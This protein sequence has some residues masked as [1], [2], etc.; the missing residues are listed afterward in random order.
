[1]AGA[2]QLSFDRI[3]HRPDCIERWAHSIRQT[4]GG[5]VAIALELSKGPLVAA[6]QK[7]DFFVLFPIH[8]T[9]LARYRSAFVPSGAKDDPTDAQ[10]ALELLLRHPE[11]FAPF[12]PQSPSM[13]SLVSL[14]EHRRHLVE[15]KVRVSNRLCS[16]LKQY[17]PVM[18][19]LFERH[20]TAVFCDFLT[21]WPTIADIKRVRIGTLEKFFNEHNARNA[22]LNQKRGELIRQAMPLTEDPGIVEPSKSYT[23]ALVEQLKVIL[24][25]VKRLD[26]E[27]QAL[28]STMT[29]YPVFESFPGA[30][31]HL[32]PRLMD[33]FESSEGAS[34]PRMTYRNTLALPR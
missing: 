24:L 23:R 25:S 30:G 26:L 1:M 34:V 27:I 28:A 2:N 8:P 19:E 6:L 20:D 4:Y 5:V 22:K 7:Y 29:D 18:L 31:K 12:Q 13:R 17:Y 32:A 3:D 11:K 10:W 14:T 16:N 21:R 9:T 33:A 15:D